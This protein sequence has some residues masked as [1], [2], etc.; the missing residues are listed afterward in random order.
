MGVMEVDGT[1][2]PSYVFFVLLLPSLNRLNELMFVGDG[3]GDGGREGDG[4]EEGRVSSQRSQT[5]S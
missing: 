1:T 3:D 4:E 2:A 5:K